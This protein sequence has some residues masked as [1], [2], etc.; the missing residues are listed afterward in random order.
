MPVDPCFHEFLSDP[1]NTVYPPP[2]HVPMEKVRRAADGAMSQGTCP[3]MAEVRDTSIDNR[4]REVPF[5]LYRP[6]SAAD[7]PVILFCHGG[8]FV[9]GSIETHDGLCRRLA[10]KT[11]AAVVSV[12]YGLSPESRFPGPVQD[13]EAVLR[14]VTGNAAAYGLDQDSIALCGDSAGAGICVSLAK[15]AVRNDIA[16]RHL[17]LIYPALD[18]GCD[19]PSQRALAD[20]PLLTQAAM[21]WF[22]S[23]YLGEPDHPDADLLPLRNAQ[24]DAMPSTTIATAEFDPLR[25]EG[26]LFADKLT[27]HGIDARLTCYKGLIHGF[28]SLP[29]SSPS[30]DAALDD[31]SNRIAASFGGH[32]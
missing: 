26:A 8:G 16:L 31:I 12:G 14:E 30:I 25:D 24:L 15:L 29:V 21:R 11:G 4:G 10:A 7:L 17:A 1:R 6:V 23:C 27:A 19:T 2:P 28:M 22:W 13:A 3:A 32:E 5:R 18:P 9:W 20:G